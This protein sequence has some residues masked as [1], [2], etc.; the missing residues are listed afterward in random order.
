MGNSTPKIFCVDDHLPNLKLLQASLKN[1]ECLLYESGES[2]LDNL[3]AEQ[4]DLIL[5]DVMM[6]GID[7]I[8]T[9]KRIRRHYP[10]SCLPVIFVSAKDSIE[11]RLKGYAAGGDDYICK[12]F[13]QAELHAK[14][15][16]VLKNKKEMDQH[17]QK[18]QETEEILGGLH[19]T[20]HVVNFLQNVLA[21]R[22]IDS[23]AQLILNTL[24]AMQLACVI[25]I[26][27]EGRDSLFYSGNENV[28]ENSIFDYIKSRGRLVSFGSKVALN[29]PNISIIIRDM[30][31]DEALGGRVRDHLALIM[32]GASSKITALQKERETLQ[33]YSM[34]TDFMA[35]L[36]DILSRLDDSYDK[37][38][39]FS[40]EIFANFVDDLDGAFMHMGLSEHQEFELRKIVEEAEERIQQENDDFSSVHR[41]FSS[42]HRQ[43]D[44][45]VEHSMNPDNDFNDD[46]IESEIVILFD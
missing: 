22:S 37:H 20:S 8:E 4:P 34:L 1:Y 11:D 42:M 16:A 27:F 2:C 6:P 35:E 13:E 38:K 18:A 46:Q 36:K 12:P 25:K 30:P 32:K 40:E 10:D 33:Q 21:V 28:L 23:V 45:V 31:D 24:Q 44:T 43:I 5:L 7:G 14:V 19:E 26:H 29:Y 3:L 17:R 9:C 15:Q 39:K 41:H